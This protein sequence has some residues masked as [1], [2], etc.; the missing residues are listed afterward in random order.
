MCM[1]N[2]YTEMREQF[3]KL[4]PMAGRVFYNLR[5]WEAKY[6]GKHAILE[7]YHMHE[8]SRVDA[9]RHLFCGLVYT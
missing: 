8:E 2:Y 3:G 1:S 6:F 5:D 9:R 4:R 7:V